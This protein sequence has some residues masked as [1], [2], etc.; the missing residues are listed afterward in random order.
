MKKIAMMFIMAL[1][2]M[3]VW[4]QSRALGVEADT[5]RSLRHYKGSDNWFIGIHA[6]MNHSLSENA[7][8]GDFMDM[9]KPGFALSVGKYFSPAVG[10]RV[11]LSYMKQQSRANSEALIDDK[12]YGF[13]NIGGYLDGLFN[14]NNIFGQY[15]ENTRFNVYGILGFGFNA[16]GGFDDKVE[17]W[18]KPA[19]GYKV[20]TDN[21][22]YFSL[23]GGLGL[24]YMLSNALDLNLEV[25]AH[26]ADD[27]YNGTRYDNKYDTYV[28]AML[29][30]TYHF[31]DHYGDRR[32]RYT[33]LSDND[34]LDELNARINA[35][36]GKVRKPERI[37]KVQREMFHSELLNT[38]VSFKIDRSSITD[39]QM[40]NVAQVAKYIQEHPDVNIV[41][42]G[43]A[44][45]KTAYP[46]YNMKLSKRRAESV[47]DALVK[48]FNVDPS[49]LRIDYKGDTI[50][51]FQMK[52]EWN[53]VVIFLTEPRK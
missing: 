29:G 46:D 39:L 41:I 3:T 30:L 16:T 44:D 25:T 48:N 9:T 20:Y 15:K 53:R 18:D 49:R 2:T 34:W 4:S 42:T 24:S 26:G 50:Q 13:H 31:K 47:R 8:F 28:A 35:E 6:G 12:N 27:A 43:Y 38:T 45:V 32:F 52:N 7:R 40:K 23:R 37:V 22:A 14:L 51:P 17:S 21:S 11:M 10:A 33:T 36:R 5:L 19:G 1:C